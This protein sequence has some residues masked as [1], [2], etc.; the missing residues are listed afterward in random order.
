MSEVDVKA[1]IPK[2][3]TKF[4]KVKCP[5]CGNEQTIFSNPA[6]NVKCNACSKVIAESSSG[7]AKLKVKSVKE[8]R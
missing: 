7:K 8:L 5:H 3:K 1:H 4:L 6:R 2:P